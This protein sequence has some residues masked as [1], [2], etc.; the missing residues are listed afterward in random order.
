MLTGITER[1]PSRVAREAVAGGQALDRQARDGAAG[2]AAASAVEGYAPRAGPGLAA[3]AQRAGAAGPSGAEARWTGG[4]P[5]KSALKKGGSG[6]GLAGS[7]SGAVRAVEPEHA[8]GTGSAGTAGSGAD[9]D[10]GCGG[11]SGEVARTAGDLGT[12]PAGEAEAAAPAGQAGLMPGADAAPSPDHEP[13]PPAP[14]AAA[15]APAALLGSGAS[16]AAV[17]SGDGRS[18]E[19][20]SSSGPPRR[21]TFGPQVR[22]LVRLV[23]ASFPALC[24]ACHS[25]STLVKTLV[26]GP[27]QVGRQ[28]P[29]GPLRRPRA[30]RVPHASRPLRRIGS[31]TR[32]SRPG[33]HGSCGSAPAR[34]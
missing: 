6:K 31:A 20:V 18:A 3:A 34:L 11:A 23:A 33:L 12:G 7:G 8:A 27:M 4:Q 24:E 15:F 14:S 26:R 16:T 2:A 17:P 25:V 1:D 10:A 9:A 28:E 32:R 29:H 30:A 22:P 5:R 21:V 13:A 19:A